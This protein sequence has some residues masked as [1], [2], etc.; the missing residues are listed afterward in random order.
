MPSL[1]NVADHPMILTPK[2]EPDVPKRICQTC[3]QSLTLDHFVSLYTESSTANCDVCRQKQ[4]EI[5]RCISRFSVWWVVKQIK[6]R[7][8]RISRLQEKVPLDGQD[9]IFQEPLSTSPI[10]T[11]SRESLSSP[12]PQPY[13][14]PC[15]SA[16]PNCIACVPS[17]VWI[18]CDYPFHLGSITVAR[19]VSCPVHFKDNF[20]RSLDV[21]YSW[22][23]CMIVG[24]VC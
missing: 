6:K 10:S 5:Y 19:A 13:L 20:P 3:G 24:N 16:S 11:A 17:L 7:K 14:F 9:M 23:S 8:M 1:S 2:E 22:F 21:S 18:P 4:R 15:T 12:I